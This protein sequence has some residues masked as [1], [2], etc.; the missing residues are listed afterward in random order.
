M[1]LA[2]DDL[3]LIARAIVQHKKSNLA[4]GKALLE[5]HFPAARTWATM[6]EANNGNLDN[7]FRTI[8]SL[9]GTIAPPDANAQMRDTGED[10]TQAGV[11]LAYIGGL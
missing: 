3:M 10:L 2:R 6:L 8:L 1:K 7:L 4:L 9:N 11:L 5:N